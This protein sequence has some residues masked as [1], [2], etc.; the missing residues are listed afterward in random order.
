[1]ARDSETIAFVALDDVALTAW[2]PLRAAERGLPLPPAALP[3]VIDNLALL[4]SQTALFL[5]ALE[6]VADESA[7]AFQP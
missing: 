1:M 3:G 2:T 7:E 4:K 6:G 5:T